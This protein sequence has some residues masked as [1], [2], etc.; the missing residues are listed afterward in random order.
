MVAAAALFLAAGFGTRAW[1][2]NNGEPAD[3]TAMA[4]PRIGLPGA[5]AVAQPQPLSLGDAARIRRIFALQRDGSA[6]EATREMDQ[7]ES[8]ILRGAILADRYLNTAYIAEKAELT[9]WLTRFADQPAIGV[10]TEQ[11]RIR[12]AVSVYNCAKI[13][14]ICRV[15]FALVHRS[16]TIRHSPSER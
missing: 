2:A 16:S 10:R 7:L 9:S 13:I 3:Q 11:F 1:S 4:I 12:E 8:D 6:A 15:H 5:R 14:S